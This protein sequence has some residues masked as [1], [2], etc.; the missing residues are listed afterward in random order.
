MIK[1]K[2]LEV[3]MTG[4]IFKLR[5]SQILQKTEYI[6]EFHQ[7]PPCLY[8]LFQPLLIVEV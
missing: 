5:N 8:K 7:I 6:R 2:N 1:Q 3:G 4:W